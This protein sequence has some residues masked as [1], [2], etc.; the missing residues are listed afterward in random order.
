MEERKGKRKDESSGSQDQV[1]MNEEN[2]YAECFWSDSLAAVEVA[3][4]MPETKRGKQGM[5]EDLGAFMVSQLRRR[6]VEVSERYLDESELAQMRQ[7]KQI[8][9]KK[10]IGAEALEV[11][12]EHLQP[13]KSEAMRMRWVLTW[14]RSSGEKSAKARCVILGYLDP[15][16]V[17]RQSAA[18]TMS[19]TTRQLL[20]SGQCFGFQGV[21]G[22]CVWRLSPR[23]GLQGDSLCDTNRGNLQ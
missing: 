17:F 12:P 1:V 5:V 18:P 15:Q 3:L 16:Y 21:Q 10:F 19:R 7:A 8:E 9:V 14:K 6:A 11:L 2:D 4:D 23:K 22:R 13:P 20:L